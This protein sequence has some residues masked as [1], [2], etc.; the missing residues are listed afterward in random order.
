MQVN[1]ADEGS[2]KQD[3]FCFR[4][5]YVATASVDYYDI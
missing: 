3:L 1:F 5:I 2:E 4:I